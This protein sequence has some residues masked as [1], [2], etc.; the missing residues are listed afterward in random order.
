MLRLDDI[1][2]VVINFFEVL[3]R[4]E[5][6]W[7]KT[8]ALLGW[9][10]PVILALASDISWVP[11]CLFGLTALSVSFELISKAMKEEP[12]RRIFFNRITSLI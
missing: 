2:K 1:I 10:A 4:I 12:V 9:T 3:G 8:I 6:E 11:V 5:T 7:S